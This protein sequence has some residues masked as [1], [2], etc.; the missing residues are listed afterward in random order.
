MSVTKTRTRDV[1]AALSA[2][3]SN[4][5]GLRVYSYV[6]DTFRP[7]GVVIGSPE[8]NYADDSAPFGL[9]AFTFPLALIHSRNTDRDAQEALD[10]FVDAV[11]VALDATQEPLLFSVEPQSAYAQPITVAGQELPGYVMRVLVRA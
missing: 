1:A 7:P 2:A 11:A 8:R 3:L 4:V 6:A 5:T 10:D 9:T